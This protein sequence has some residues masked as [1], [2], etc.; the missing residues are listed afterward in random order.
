MYVLK[1]WLFTS[2]DEIESWVTKLI[3]ALVYF[4]DNKFKVLIHKKRKR[5]GKKYVDK[6]DI[7]LQ[8]PI[9]KM[10]ANKI[11]FTGQNEDHEES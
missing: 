11:F 10:L 1:L 6:Q 9:G 4:I 7:N 8:N 3:L 5:Q 2:L